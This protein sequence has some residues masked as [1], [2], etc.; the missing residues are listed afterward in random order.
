MALALLVL[1][2]VPAVA[3]PTDDADAVARR[4]GWGYLL[5]RLIADGVPRAR[6][7]AVFADPRVPAFDGL[8]FN[9][10]PRE[11]RGPYRRLQ[12]AASVREARACR[13]RHAEAFAA[14]ERRE[15]VP[16]S[17]IAAIIHVESGCG[18]MTGSNVVLHRLARLAMA[19]EPGNL[20]ANMR[21]HTA[22]SSD[23][24]VPDVVRRR[25][26]YLED[27]FYP[28]VRAVFTIADQLGIDPLGMEGSPAGAFGYPQFLPTSYLRFGVDGNGDGRVSLYDMADAAASCARYLAQNGWTPDV[29][30]AGKRA[31]IWRYNRSEIYIDTILAIDRQLNH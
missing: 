19:N 16:A 13:A 23:P 1:A 25:A 31:V 10:V 12:S 3:H 4:H 8:P 28:E 24:T 26:R 2:S 29:D 5:D 7:A 15:R 11:A 21:R 6:V 9:L 22:D 20:D 27:T 14:A 18:R 30:R 17:V